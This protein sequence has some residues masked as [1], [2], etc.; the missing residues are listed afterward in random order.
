MVS[1]SFNYTT[2]HIW[3]AI[4]LH[5]PE[6]AY[7]QPMEDKIASQVYVDR[8]PV[9]FQKIDEINSNR[10]IYSMKKWAW[11]NHNQVR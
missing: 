5:K 7:L 11:L 1:M 3:L 6:M 10:I 2:V 9:V 8:R 4:L